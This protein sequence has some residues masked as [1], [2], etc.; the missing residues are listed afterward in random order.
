MTLK[1]Q[2]DNKQK[3]NTCKYA[4]QVQRRFWE[5]LHDLV[6]THP[7]LRNASASAELLAHDCASAELLALGALPTSKW[8]HAIARAEL[9]ETC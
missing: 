9:L 5:S 8:H 4:V 6:H 2:Q 7:R 1:R 3:Q